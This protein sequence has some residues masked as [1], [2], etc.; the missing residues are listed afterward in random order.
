MSQ[1][2]PAPI[3][4]GILTF[5]QFEPLDVW[6]FVDAFSIARFIGT[7]DANPPAYPFEILFI[8]NQVRPRGK[9][10]TPAPVKSANGPRVAPDPDL[11]QQT[12]VNTRKQFMESQDFQSAVIEAIADNQ[13]AHNTMADYFFSDGPGVNAVIMALADAFY[14]AAIDHQTDV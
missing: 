9:N 8:S 10:Q 3:R 12:Q 1:T 6:G 5:E 11:V 4:V 13:E 2:Y 7:G 14:E